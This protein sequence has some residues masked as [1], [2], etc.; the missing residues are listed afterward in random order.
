MPTPVACSSVPHDTSLESFLSFLDSAVPDRTS[1]Q[2]VSPYPSERPC[3]GFTTPR[4][5]TSRLPGSPPPAFPPPNLL[6][7]PAVPRLHLVQ[8]LALKLAVDVTARASARTAR[9]SSG[10]KCVL[11]ASLRVRAPAVICVPPPLSLP[12]QLLRRLQ[13]P[14]LP[15]QHLLLLLPQALPLCLP[16]KTY[17]KLGSPRFTMSP[18][19]LDQ[20]GHRPLV[21][22][23]RSSAPTPLSSLLGQSSLCCP[24]VS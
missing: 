24:N 16:S 12:H 11:A 3:R 2:P 17:F 6:L 20:R 10:A 9:V 18:K 15:L 1:P 8:S 14:L 13:L 23:C 21:M 4:S 7:L 5:L 19:L 22:F